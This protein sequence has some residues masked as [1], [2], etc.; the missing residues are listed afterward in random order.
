MRSRSRTAA[1]D[2]RAARAALDRGGAPARP[3]AAAVPAAGAARARVPVR[4]RGRRL[5]ARRD[6][7]RP[8]TRTPTST[9]SR[10]AATP[11]PRSARSASAPNG[12]GQTIVQLTDERRGQAARRRLA[13]VRVVRHATRGAALGLQHDVEATPKGG[14]ILNTF[15]PSADAAATRSSLVDATDAEGRCHDQGVG[16]LAGRRPHGGLE[17]IDVTEPGR[18][19]SRSASR[20]TSARRTRS[21]STPSARTSPTP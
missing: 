10:A 20:A 2:D 1:G 17:I 21:T 7:S 4:R 11:T 5:G 6:A 8:A 16:G 14:A 13:A 12:G 18:R 15:N 3:R 19:R 9:S